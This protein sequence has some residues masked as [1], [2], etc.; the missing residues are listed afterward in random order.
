MSARR[1]SEDEF[2]KIVRSL[3]ADY[4]LDLRGPNVHVSPSKRRLEKQTE[5]ET[6]VYELYQRLRI[7]HFGGRLAHRLGK[8]KQEAPRIS[9]AWVDKPLADS[10]T[11]PQVSAPLGARS[12]GERVAL[13]CCLRDILAG[14]GR[15]D[16]RAS[17]DGH[18]LSSRRTKFR[19]QRTDV[20]GAIDSIPI[21]SWRRDATSSSREGLPSDI[22]QSFI[23]S[24]ANTS[25]TS[26]A[27][28]IFSNKPLD[29]AQETPDSTQNTK[30]KPSQ[31]YAPCFQDLQALQESF[32]SFEDSGRSSPEGSV[33]QTLRS[34]ETA[35][36]TSPTAEVKAWVL[37][38]R[39]RNIWRKSLGVIE[40]V[41]TR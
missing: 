36:M 2:R 12:P 20:D 24:S 16:K 17:D 22:D 10:D 26:L 34:D 27:S 25:K 8:F 15:P 33:T 31:E 9:R 6:L 5:E 30:K 23:Y 29:S 3:N 1:P 39:L 32:T 21:R 18:G 13:Q 38:D 19:F 14:S 11:L 4:G 40:I 37:E 35:R 7:H 28:T 41:N